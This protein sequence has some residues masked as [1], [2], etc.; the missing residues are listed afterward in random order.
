MSPQQRDRVIPLR[1]CPDT[2]MNH[3]SR[4]CLKHQ[5]GLCAAPCVGLID[6]A[7]YMDL[8]EK[9][10]RPLCELRLPLD[11]YDA[12]AQ[13]GQHGCLVAGAG[14][15]VQDLGRRSGVILA[16]GLLTEC[17]PP[18]GLFVADLRAYWNR[19]RPVCGKRVRI[20]AR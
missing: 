8:V 20:D 11:R 15:Y 19:L 5:I 14:S 18:R 17:G 3:R 9:A 2:V 12:G 6:D 10:S 13:L 7:A 4:P 16:P 1:D